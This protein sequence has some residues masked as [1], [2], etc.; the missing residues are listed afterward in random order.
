LWLFHGP[1]I[2]YELAAYES[3][4]SLSVLD[5]QRDRHPPADTAL[6]FTA[7]FLPGPHVRIRKAR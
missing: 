7:G 6:G 3:S 1:L 5:D 4:K 2:E